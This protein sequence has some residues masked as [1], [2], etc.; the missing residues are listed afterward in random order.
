MKV[1]IPTIARNRF[2]SF[3]V[4]QKRLIEHNAH[5]QHAYVERE[6]YKKIQAASRASPSARRTT[7]P[8]NT[9]EGVHHI[10]VDAMQ[11]QTIP[12]FRQRDQ[13]SR[14]YYLSGVSVTPMAVFDEGTGE[15]VVYLYDST[16]PKTCSDSVISCIDRFLTD[17]QFGFKHLHVSL[18][19]YRANKSH[20]V[21]FT[22]KH[23]TLSQ[24]QHRQSTIPG[25]PFLTIFR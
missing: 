13:P 16:A 19:N 1:R 23:S 25:I 7:T 6:Y 22:H 24:K 15:A 2:H 18:D 12:T 11:A 8:W 3:S 9:I 5:V 4:F 21:L 14:T 17:Y 20:V 10:S